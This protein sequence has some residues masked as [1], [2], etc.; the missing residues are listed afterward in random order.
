MWYWLIIFLTAIIALVIY[1]S[2]ASGLTGG[3]TGGPVSGSA[4]SLYAVTM[5][6]PDAPS[7]GNPIYADYLHWM[8]V[9]ATAMPDWNNIRGVVGDVIV[10][11][12]PPSPPK[13]SGDHRYYTRIW[14]QA[15]QHQRQAQRETPEPIISRSN[16]P[17]EQYAKSRGWKLLDEKIEVVT[18]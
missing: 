13:G 17:L 11:Y 8:V 16:F 1:E 14:K 10:E 3:P 4:E 6:D 9:N 2:G 18:G 7:R 12:A 15:P 5:T